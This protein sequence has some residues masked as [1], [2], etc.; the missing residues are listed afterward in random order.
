MGNIIHN[1]VNAARELKGWTWSELN[2]KY[3]EKYYVEDIANTAKKWKGETF[4][5]FGTVINLADILDCDIDYLAGLQ[6]YPRKTEVLLEEKTGIDRETWG[7]LL[8]VTQ[9]RP[10]LKQI[11]AD[12]LFSGLG[13][14]SYTNVKGISGL[15]N[16]IYDLIKLDIPFQ[17]DFCYGVDCSGYHQQN[18]IPEFN[19]KELYSIFFNRIVSD[20]D[21]FIKQ[22][23]KKHGDSW[24]CS[25]YEQLEEM[26]DNKESVLLK[27][28]SW[29]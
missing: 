29:K 12:F 3:K 9:D 18:T 20:L 17:I 13:K 27:G 14:H 4:P 10:E 24:S 23:R 19:P 28:S 8:E 16:N 11:I 26:L 5:N 21:L 25:D 6:E 22:Q 2:Q 7:K 1:R 15:L